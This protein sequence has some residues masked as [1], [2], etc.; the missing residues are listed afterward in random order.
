LGVRASLRPGD[1][2]KVLRVSNLALDWRRGI[3]E[4]V[5]PSLSPEN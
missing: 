5:G 3:G 2:L 4:N 1:P